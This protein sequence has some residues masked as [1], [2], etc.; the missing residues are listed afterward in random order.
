MLK[1]SKPKKPIEER[2]KFTK[3]TKLSYIVKN[4]QLYLMALPGLMLLL[5]FK[6]VPMYGLLIAFKKYNVLKGVI[7][8]KWVGFE[9]F[10]RFLTM[11]SFK[12]LFMNTFSLSVYGLIFGF[13]FPILIALLLNQIRYTGLKNNIQ[14]ILYAPNFISTVVVVGMIFI[15]FAPNG[16]TN[17]ILAKIGLEP[18]MFMTEPQWF[19][20]L[21][22][23]TSIWQ[24]AGWGSVIYLAA[25]SNVDPQLHEA[26]KIDGANILQRIRHIEIPTI[27]P[28]ASILLILSVGGIMALGHEKAYIMQTSLNMSKAEIL[29]T[30]VYKIGL[31]AG[32]YSFSTA[33]GLF[34]SIINLF[35]LVSVN[36]VVK[37]FDKSSGL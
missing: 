24:S 30:Y 37:K 14:L 2:I 9:H 25:L 22:I 5:L 15:F 33:V 20:P 19:Q 36:F 3:N 27:L 13:G 34:N 7:G 16:P 8:S 32:D 29:A 12:D 1:N 23:S 28:V 17:V 4:Y 26:A 31:Q 18:I 6:Y 21:Y 10:H 11:E 35:L